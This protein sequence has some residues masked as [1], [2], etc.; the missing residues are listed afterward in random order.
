MR[1][2]VGVWLKRMAVGASVLLV[3]AGCLIVAGLAFRAWD[4]LRA[5]PLEA[6]HTF[7]PDEPNA[8]TIDDLDWAGYVKVE[9][10]LFADVRREVF[11]TP[12]DGAAISIDRYVTGSPVDPQT[13][14][15]DCKTMQPELGV[16]ASPASSRIAQRSLGETSTGAMPLSIVQ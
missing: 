13:F 10:R 15:T 2:T 7:V 6:W 4:A 5:P 1:T 9:E 14:G 8:G 11:R 16:S 12:D 3:L